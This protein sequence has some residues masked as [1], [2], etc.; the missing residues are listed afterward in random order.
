MWKPLFL[1]VCKYSGLRLTVVFLSVLQKAKW[2][3]S[4]VQRGGKLV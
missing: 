1:C 2:V 4:N 3:L